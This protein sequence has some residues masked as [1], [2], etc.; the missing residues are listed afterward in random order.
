VDDKI[1]TAEVP[2]VAAPARDN[3]MLLVLTLGML[4]GVA[5]CV[6]VITAFRDDAA[7]ASTLDP[8]VKPALTSLYEWLSTVVYVVPVG[9]WIAAIAVTR[10]GRTRR[11]VA[12]QFTAALFVFALAW[13]AGAWLAFVFMPNN[14][15]S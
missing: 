8:N 2:P 9:T 6:F 10:L 1:V 15:S 14:L 11:A 13:P 3:G 12:R 5:A 4:A 7:A